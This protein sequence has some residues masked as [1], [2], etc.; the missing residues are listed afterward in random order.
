[1]RPTLTL[2]LCVLGVTYCFDFP[3]PQAALADENVRTV[4][5]PKFLAEY[6]LKTNTIPDRW[7]AA[8][9]AGN[10]EQGTLVYQTGP[11]S[12]RFDV[13]CSAA[14]DHRPWE[15][16]DLSEKHVEVLNRGRHFIGHLRLNMPADLTGGETRV[17]LWDAE[18]TGALR[19]TNGQANWKAIVHA[20]EPVIFC[21]L[22]ATG[23]LSDARFEYVPEAPRNPRSVRAKTPRT[24][25]HPEVKTS[26]HDDG[27]HV[28]VQDL[29][30]GGQTAVAWFARSKGNRTRLWLSV[31]HSFP[32]QSAAKDAIAAVRQARDAEFGDWIAQHQAWWHRY[33]Q[34]SFLETGDKFWDRFYWIQQYKLG[35]ATRDEGWIID[36]QGPWLQPTA[37]NATWWNL[38]AQLSHLG[39]LTANRRGAVSAL[40]YQLDRNESNLRINVAEAYR[41]DSSAL[42]RSSSGWDL[43]A[44]AGEPGGRDGMDPRIGAECGNLLWALHNVDLEYR[45]WNDISVRDETLFP[46]LV[47]AVN[48]YRHFLKRGHDDR[49]HLPKTYS[50]EYRLASDCTYDLDLLYWAVGRLIELAAEK[51]LTESDEPLVIVWR[52]LRANLVEVQS[53]ETGRAVGGDT[54]LTGGHRHWS[55]LMAIYPLRTLTPNS[56]QDRDLIERSL[57]HWRSFGRGIAGYSHTAGSCMASLLGDG[58]QALEYLNQLRTYLK[59]NTFY[60]EIGL[61]VMETPLHGATAMQD[62][63]LQSHGGRLA[64]FPAVPAAWPDARFANFRGEGGY[65]VSGELNDGAC[66]YVSIVSTSGG[67]VTVALPMK[68]FRWSSLSHPTQS[69]DH[70]GEL[71]LST[72]PGDRFVFWQEGTARPATYP[73]NIDSFAE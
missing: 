18:A 2:L 55:H 19:S 69:H 65:L 61:P 59:P 50:P 63:V 66:R 26:V 10:G 34:Q 15:Q 24:P 68:K 17:S 60:S 6:D 53:N 14:H 7:D 37:W 5:W 58:D 73:P 27:V 16:D 43:V 52:D 56:Q 42:G 39:G 46:L 23:E 12:M 72:S 20:N 57:K 33:Y 40:R 71:R 25:P 31:Q 4:D 38:N 35:C 70:E 9:F 32:G 1:M 22:S 67:D 44:H 30:A 49:W 45:Y 21:E 11:R 47:R 36:N 64:V 51:N 54:W 3:S 28:A 29:I 13:G 62:M 8:P 41:D 48:Y